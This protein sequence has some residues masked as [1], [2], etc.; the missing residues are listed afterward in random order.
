[1]KYYISDAD[2]GLR[3]KCLEKKKFKKLK[4]FTV[5]FED[6]KLIKTEGNYFPK[7]N[8][9]ETNDTEENKSL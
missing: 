9:A 5:Y 2:D 7:E 8:N 6:D 3:T 1:M 4:K